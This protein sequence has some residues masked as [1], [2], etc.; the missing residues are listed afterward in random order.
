[1]AFAFRHWLKLEIDLSAL[2]LGAGAAGAL[3]ATSL[4]LVATALALFFEFDDDGTRSAGHLPQKKHEKQRIA[5]E[6]SDAIGA[7]GPEEFDDEVDR[8]FE[9]R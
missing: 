4:P 9:K 2:A 6:A 8:K 3:P 7:H 5:S 1:L